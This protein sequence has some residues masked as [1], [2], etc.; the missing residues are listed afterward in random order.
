LGRGQS[1]SFEHLPA[2]TPI[3]RP[4]ALATSA[5]RPGQVFGKTELDVARI[6]KLV[7]CVTGRDEFPAESDHITSSVSIIT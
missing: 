4:L 3:P 1:A 5:W 7:G 2:A 6:S